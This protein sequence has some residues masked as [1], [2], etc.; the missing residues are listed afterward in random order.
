[1]NL[2]Q[3]KLRRVEEND[4]TL[5]GLYIGDDGDIFSDSDYSQLLGAAIGENTHLKS[6][7][8]VL[9]GITLNV[10]NR[11]FY[12]GLKQNMSI[13]ELYLDCRSA[14][15]I[16]SGV[17]HEILKIYQENNNL[18]RLRIDYADLQNG[19]NS[20]ITTTLRNCTNLNILL[21]HN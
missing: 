17:G 21:H 4:E 2:C 14:R 15:N 7:T 12:D 6:L 10:T 3:I 11:E 19:G 1:M 16:V 5:T 9:D 13:Y 20:V 8:V 18:T